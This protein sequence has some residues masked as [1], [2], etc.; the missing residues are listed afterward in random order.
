MQDDESGLGERL[1]LDALP[2]LPLDPEAQLAQERVRL[3]T[4][5]LC[6][7]HTAGVRVTITNLQTGAKT[8]F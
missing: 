3:I 1:V 4:E 6:L 2:D 7:L 8:E 5:A